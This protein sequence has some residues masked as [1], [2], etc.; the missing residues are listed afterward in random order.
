MKAKG[1]VSFILFRWE[2]SA[3]LNKLESS[4]Q[5]QISTCQSC[6]QSGLRTLSLDFLSFLKSLC[7]SKWILL[8]ISTLPSEH[9]IMGKYEWMESNVGLGLCWWRLD[10]KASVSQGI[11]LKPRKVFAPFF[12]IFYLVRLD[13]DIPTPISALLWICIYSSRTLGYKQAFETKPDSL[14]SACSQYI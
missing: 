5:F 14:E 7:K 4:I 12:K 3:E 2:K 8:G 9:G 13:E 6:W 11:N 10:L 1:W